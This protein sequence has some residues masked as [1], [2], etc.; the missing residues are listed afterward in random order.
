MRDV[1]IAAD[2]IRRVDDDDPLDQFRREHASAFAEQRGLPDSRAAEKQQAFAG[3][4][5][6]AKDIDSAENAAADSSRQA[7][8]LVMAISN[9]RNPMECPLDSSSII[10]RKRADTMSHV[11]D[12]FARDC[13]IAEIDRPARK[14]S[15]GRAAK[16]HDDF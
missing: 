7:H 1:A 13:Q 12:I 10:E 4:H 14:S 2:F 11:V 9:S 3:F 8:Y 6:V 5:N 16:V 15:F